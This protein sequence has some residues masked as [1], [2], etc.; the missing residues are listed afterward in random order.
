MYFAGI[1]NVVL[2]IE[3]RKILLRCVAFCDMILINAM[4]LFQLKKL[5]MTR[6]LREN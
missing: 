4:L 6:K 5:T 1:N 3:G 2:P